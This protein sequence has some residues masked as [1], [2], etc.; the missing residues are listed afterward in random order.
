MTLLGA[1]FVPSSCPLD[2]ER[3]VHRILQPQ[4]IEREWFYIYMNQ[5][6]LEQLVEQALMLIRK[7]S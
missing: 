3:E 4:L 7:S 6:I 2:I 5:H 1:F